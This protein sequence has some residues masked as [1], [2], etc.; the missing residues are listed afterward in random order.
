MPETTTRALAPAA[1]QQ[2]HF[3]AV[4]AALKGSKPHARE[5]DVQWRSDVVALADLF[6]RNNPKFERAMFMRAC[7]FGS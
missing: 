2:R 4:A 1:F 6:G 3:I 5:L 7:G